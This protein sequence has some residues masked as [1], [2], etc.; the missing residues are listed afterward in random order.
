MSSFL[1]LD[2]SF[3]KYRLSLDRSDL[4]TD[5]LTTDGRP[6]SWYGLT[7]RYRYM[8]TRTQRIAQRVD[9]QRLVVDQPA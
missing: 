3:M 5:M 2:R 7:Y 4:R 1:D 6:P 8:C 9:E